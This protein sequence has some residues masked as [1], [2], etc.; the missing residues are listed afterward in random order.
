MQPVA[1]V[2][3]GLIALASATAYAQDL[4][5]YYPDDYATMIEASRNEGTLLVY[6]NIGPRN[7]SPIIEGFN[8]RY[9]WI[10]VE[11][12][13]LNSGEVFSRFEAEIG[14]DVRTADVLVSVSPD[15]WLLAAEQGALADY[16]SPE[17]P[18]LPDFASAPGG[19]YTLST[20]PV[21]LI[22]NR[23]LVPEDEAPRGLAH[24]AEIATAN[25]DVYDDRITTYAGQGAFSQTIWRAVMFEKGEAGWQRMAALAPLIRVSTGS[26]ASMV[27]ATTSGEFLVSYLVSGISVFSRLGDP[28]TEELLGV[29]F[30]EDG[31]PVVFRGIAVTATAANPN[32]ARL[33]LDHALSNEGQTAAG[34]GG[35]T[36]YREDVAEDTVTHYTYQAIAEEIGEENIIRATFNAD[37][38]AYTDEF[39][40]RWAETVLDAQ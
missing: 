11:T 14:A 10:E 39:V 38:V 33:F 8:R 34:A 35:L 15:R 25:P 13:D 7:W 32:A 2:V 16:R 22:Y 6:S 30:P 17:A 31:T 23:V 24:L 26:T 29:V 5:D 18:Y 3:T 27:E 40:A 12:L 37:H 9:P 1:C 36:P 21:V 19:L 4:P 28:G 20:D